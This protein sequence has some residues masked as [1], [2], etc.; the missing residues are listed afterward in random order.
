MEKW[1]NG[2]DPVLCKRG[3]SSDATVKIPLRYFGTKLLYYPPCL[4]PGTLFLHAN[5]CDHYEHRCNQ[6]CNHVN[7]VNFARFAR[8]LL[9]RLCRHFSLEDEYVHDKTPNSNTTS[10]PIRFVVYGRLPRCIDLLS[11]E[12]QRVDAVVY[13][14]MAIIRKVGETT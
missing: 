2:S 4:P 12:K 8:R 5:H 9:T 11:T 14:T 6:N 1:E 13:N 7:H 3:I 10:T